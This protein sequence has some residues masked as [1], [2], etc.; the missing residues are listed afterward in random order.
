MKAVALLCDVRGSRD[1]PDR[2]T[3]GRE[4]RDAL[5]RVTHEYR[6]NL[7]SR[8][9]LQAGI[10]EFG[11][12]LKP[13]AAGSVVIRLWEELQPKPIRYAL[14]AGSVDVLVDS[15]ESTGSE[16]LAEFS[17]ADG[18]ALHRAADL[19]DELRTSG[20]LFSAQLGGD[21][22]TAD[23]LSLLGEMT[24]LHVLSWTARQSEIFFS[25]RRTG[26]QTETAEEL[27]IQ[28]STVS[29][30]L[31]GLEHRPILRSLDRIEQRM[32]EAPNG[33]ESWS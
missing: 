28:Q 14:A 1:L 25:Y 12:V 17:S 4:L 27:G 9:E 3:F 5:R 30:T 6:T 13:N 18:P 15:T 33:G 29:H 21:R 2:S 20:S 16:R 31:S 24:Y 10:D 8:L 26:L 32:N 7:L 11:A 23:L 19:L 22:S